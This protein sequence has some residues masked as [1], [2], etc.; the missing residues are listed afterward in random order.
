MGSVY[1]GRG[2]KGAYHYLVDK[3]S[4]SMGKRA[5]LDVLSTQAHFVA[6]RQQRTE[7]KSFCRCPIDRAAAV[8]ISSSQAL[9]SRLHVRSHEPVMHVKR[10]R[11]RNRRNADADKL[12]AGDASGRA[13]QQLRQR[14]LTHFV[15]LA[16]KCR[17]IPHYMCARTYRAMTLAQGASCKS[18]SSGS[19]KFGLKVSLQDQASTTLSHFY[20]GGDSSVS[21]AGVQPEPFAALE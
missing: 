1:E 20:S 7:S 15:P 13:L 9:Y 12:A 18:E 10:S 17:A 8:A 3:H 16:S 2:R 11:Y 5:T 6:L 21:P 4:M 19:L 14:S